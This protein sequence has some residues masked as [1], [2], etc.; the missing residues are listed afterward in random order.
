MT[1]ESVDM[2][3]PAHEFEWTSLLEVNLVKSDFS[4]EWPCFAAWTSTKGDEADQD[5]RR[6]L[7]NRLMADRH[8]SPFEH[9]NATWQVTAPIMVW[10]EHHRH[11]IASYNEES[12]RYRK[13]RPRFYIP[14]RHR[15]MV[16]VPGTKAM[17]YVIAPVESSADYE[18][19]V[20]TL[21]TQARY[22]YWAYE[23]L[24]S[25]GFVREISRAALPVDLMSTCIVTMNARALMNYLSLRVK[26]EDSAYPSN[27]QWEINEVAL[28]YE[29]HFQ[30]AAPLT[31]KAFVDNGRVCP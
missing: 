10:R 2:M 4:D 17:D 11:R 27:P 23:A 12:A 31:Y 25:R 21:Q 6:G 1:D 26:S 22:N 8:G 5:A 28:A 19:L 29:K 16:Q 24:L 30:V 14:P 20:N 3:T 13:M 7:I 18:F 9:M 15:P